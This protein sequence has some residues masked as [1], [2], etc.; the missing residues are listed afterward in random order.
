MFKF[1]YGDKVKDFV[2]GF[3]GTITGRAEYMTGC[4]QYVV[5]PPVG[6][7]GTFREGIWIDEDRLKVVSK[8]RTVK[9]KTKK[10]R[11]GG[12]QHTPP[13]NF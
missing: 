3:K 8:K 9:K 6:K 11:V 7:D 12:P 1:Q 5:A 10:K 2:S 13:R 4:R